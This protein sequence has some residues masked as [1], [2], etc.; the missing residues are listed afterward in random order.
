MRW[1][2][3]SFFPANPRCYSNEFWDKIDYSSASAKD[4]CT[5][6]SPTPYFGARAMQWRCVN[7]SSENSCCHGNQPFLFKD[8]MAAGL[9]ELYSVAMGQIPRSA[10][11]ISSFP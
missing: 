8:K 5:L 9:Q 6:F 11:R 3:L 10:E 4:K 2:H 7:F 1:C